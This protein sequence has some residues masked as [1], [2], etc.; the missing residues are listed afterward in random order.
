MSKESANEMMRL[1]YEDKERILSAIKGAPIGSMGYQGEAFKHDTANAP[2][3]STKLE[4]STGYRPVLTRKRLYAYSRFYQ[5]YE[6]G[7]K[8]RP[9][10][11]SGLSGVLHAVNADLIFNQNR[12]QVESAI[13]N[14]AGRDLLGNVD[15]SAAE[16]KVARFCK[17]PAPLRYEIVPE[18][19]L[20]AAALMEPRPVSRNEE[21]DWSRYEQNCLQ[22]MKEAGFQVDRTSGGAD[23]GADIVARKGQRT[24][25]VQC[26]LYTR[27]V[28][29]H[30][31]QE[32]IAARSH[33]VADFAVVCSES[34]FTAAAS[35]LAATN[36]VHSTSLER[37]GRVDDVWQ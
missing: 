22:E 27:A 6:W 17:S 10:V 24:F 4:T 34:G 31:V 15:Y 7:T 32:V 13:R 26:K 30:S 9:S 33:Y 35:N 25:V 29:I 23:Y 37:L 12:V 5:A 20:I 1:Y 11:E 21:L 8:Y 2:L 19:L 16:R 36:S 18:I 28:G 3:F 14:N